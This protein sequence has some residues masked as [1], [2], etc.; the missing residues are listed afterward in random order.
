MSKTKVINL[1][2]GAGIGKSTLA[3]KV[4]GML[5]DKGLNVELVREYAKEL[6]WADDMTTL[7]NQ[8]LVFEEQARRQSILNGKVDYIITDSPLLLSIIYS[9][10]HD[11]D[12]EIVEEYERYDNIEVLLERHKAYN[13]QGR[14]Q[15]LEESKDVDEDIKHLLDCQAANTGVPYKRFQNKAENAHLFI[16]EVL[17][18]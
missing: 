5:K 1:Y 17:G 6:V 18:L 13:P 2:G 16:E 11:L 10:F 3:C 9:P 15:D 8:C 12:E 7:E 14:L 4:F